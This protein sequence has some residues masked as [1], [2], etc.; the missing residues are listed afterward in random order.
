MYKSY[1][2]YFSTHIKFSV[3]RRTEI[4]EN[5]SFTV[6]QKLKQLVNLCVID[7]TLFSK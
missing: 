1:C 4:K 3:S 2:H 6:K 5:I 7:L